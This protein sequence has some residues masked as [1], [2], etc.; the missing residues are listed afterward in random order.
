VA[1]AVAVGVA[2]L[3]VGYFAVLGLAVLVGGCAVGCWL[4]RGVGCGRLQWRLFAVAA[5][6]RL[7]LLLSLR[8]CVLR[9]RLAVGVAGG[10]AVAG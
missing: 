7:G 2:L 3:G 6:V 9:W 5:C 8:C 4:L 10:C 1:L